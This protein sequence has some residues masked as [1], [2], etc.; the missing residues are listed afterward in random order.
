M[1]SFARLLAGDETNPLGGV[2]VLGEESPFRLRVLVVSEGIRAVDDFLDS[3]DFI[4]SC[5][6]GL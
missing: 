4:G 2:E 1:I 3:G 6:S 5:A